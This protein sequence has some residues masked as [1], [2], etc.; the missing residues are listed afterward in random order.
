M[1]MCRH[2]AGG[3]RARAKLGSHVAAPLKARRS[4]PRQARGGEESRQ[5]VIFA[6]P[7]GG[8]VPAAGM[9]GLIVDMLDLTVD[10]LGQRRP[11]QPTRTRRSTCGYR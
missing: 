3:G 4:W 5:V 6:D 8:G 2:H 1:T 11:A 10:E 9:A 7:S